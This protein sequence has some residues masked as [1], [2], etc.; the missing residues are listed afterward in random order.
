MI[1]IP[2]LS[3]VFG[4]VGWLIDRA[5]TGQFV[6][7]SLGALLGYVV[8]VRSRCTGLARGEGR[9]HIG[10]PIIIVIATLFV[11]SF[12][13]NLTFQP[14]A[15]F[16]T[17]TA[18]TENARISL[19]L[20]VAFIASAVAIYLH[21]RSA[22]IGKTAHIIPTVDAAVEGV[23]LEPGM[24]GLRLIRYLRGGKKNQKG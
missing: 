5:V 20:V 13:V 11:S 23:F 4:L 8:W 3:I 24:L 17:P 2:L 22:K 18:T 7:S 1:R 12:V 21:W 14:L 10:S 15:V 6:F 16:D 19:S 9:F